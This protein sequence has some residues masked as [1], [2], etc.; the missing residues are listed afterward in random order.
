VGSGLLTGVLLVLIPLVDG[1]VSGWPVWSWILL[2]AGVPAGVVLAGWEIRLARR[3][4]EPV[5]Q[6]NLLRRRSFTMGQALAL[7][8]FAGFTSLFFT[9][10]ILWQQGLGRRALQ[11]G[12]LVLPFAVASLSTASN[13]YRFSTRFGRK[14]MQGGIAA[15]FAGL[16][17]ML[18][19]LHL[20][21]PP[22]VLG[23]R[24]TAVPGW[25]RKRPDHRA[26]PGLRP[27]LGTPGPGR[28]GRRRADH[29]PADRHGHRHRGDRDRAVRQRQ[30]PE[31]QRPAHAVADAHGPVGHRAEPGLR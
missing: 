15:M 27:G 17:L 23:A 22:R 5:L 11:T 3:G 31:Q 21:A 1:R 28:H 6:V 29:G 9:L 30:R 14:T 7:L 26:E 2:A 4:G 8:Y 20:S 25:A 13:S 18:L 16:A 24:R 12:L 19:V 10:S